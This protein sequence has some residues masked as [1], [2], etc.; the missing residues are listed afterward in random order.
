MCS[1]LDLLYGLKTWK[2]AREASTYYNLSQGHS[3][4]LTRTVDIFKVVWNNVEGKDSNKVS[5]G[6]NI[7]AQFVSFFF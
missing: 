4:D 7:M 1:R 5:K 2:K 6:G 3:D